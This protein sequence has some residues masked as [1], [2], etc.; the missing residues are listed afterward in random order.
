MLWVTD[1]GG[2]SAPGYFDCGLT[3][4]FSWPLSL[5]HGSKTHMTGPLARTA[6]HLS[7]AEPIPLSVKSRA[8]QHPSSGLRAPGWDLLLHSEA[9]HETDK[10]SFQLCSAGQ[11]SH[12]PAQLKDPTEEMSKYLQLSFFFIIIN[13]SFVVVEV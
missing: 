3:V 11:R 1:L 7:S 4:E 9:R 12:R 6:G 10:A 8:V 2:S 5:L 13:F